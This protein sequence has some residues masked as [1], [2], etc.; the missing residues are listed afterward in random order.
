[1]HYMITET[2]L[3]YAAAFVL[4]LAMFCVARPWRSCL[5]RLLNANAA[6][7]LTAFTVAMAATLVV[8]QLGGERGLTRAARVPREALLVESVAFAVAIGITFTGRWIAKKKCKCVLASVS[9]LLTLFL[10]LAL[11]PYFWRQRQN[12]SN[13]AIVMD[14]ALDP[15]TRRLGDSLAIADVLVGAVK[16]GDYL[17]LRDGTKR[18]TDPALGAA[19]CRKCLENIDS[20]VSVND[21][22]AHRIVQT[23]LDSL[24][25]H[26]A[27][28]TA[29]P[30][31]VPRT[32]DGRGGQPHSVWILAYVGVTTILCPSLG[33]LLILRHQLRHR[34]KR[35]QDS[36]SI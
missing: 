4:A 18:L 32:Q 19:D 23:A 3:M 28:S 34:G 31:A 20:Y 14:V 10:L 8:A 24:H 21:S 1:M 12:M 33:T 15:T 29:A 5:D 2:R 25:A 26:V 36:Q 27:A 6:L 9:S 35:N 7:L 17:L 30:P 22:F 16:R 13:Q 11:G